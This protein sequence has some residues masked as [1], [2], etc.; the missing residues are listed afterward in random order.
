MVIELTPFSL[1][2]RDTIVAADIICADEDDDADEENH[3][4]DE[5][6]PLLLSVLG[7]CETSSKK[8]NLLITDDIPKSSAVSKYVVYLC[9]LI[10]DTCRGI[11]FPTL[12]S[13]VSSL[14]GT[15]STQGLVLAAF[16]AGRIVGS[17]AFGYMSEVQGYRVVLAACNIC[18]LIGTVMYILASR[19]WMVVIAQ[20]VIG[21][22][23]GR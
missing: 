2:N 7:P 3:H 5:S 8:N 6:D 17:T 15:R 11:I 18:I 21:F 23:A 19:I 16:S 14:G 12:W 1:R 10:G 9:I 22:G 4:D 13:L 20:L